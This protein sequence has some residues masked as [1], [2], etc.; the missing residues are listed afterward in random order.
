MNPRLL[1]ATAAA[2]H[3]SGLSASLRTKSAAGYLM[4]IPYAVL[5]VV[6]IVVPVLAAILLS[7]TNFNMLEF[8]TWKGLENYLHLFL[9]DD[10]FLIAL[11]NTLLY[12]MITGPLGYLLS[13]MMAWFVNELS[14][15]ARS[16]LTLL[17]Y[18]PTLAGNIYFIWTYLFSGD[19]YGLINSLL[20]TTG[21]IK[22]PLQWLKDP[23][24]SSAVVIVV[25]IW[26]SMGT[27]FLSLIA[28][29]QSLNHELFEAAA[30]DGVR[31][32]YQELWYVTLPQMVPQLL[33]AAV[34]SISSAFAVGY[35]NAALTGFPSTDYATH[36]I[37]LHILDYGSIRF[38]MGYASA[39]AV[40]LF[41]LMTGAYRITAKLIGKVGT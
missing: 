27:G 10:I 12:A 37:L 41:I 35:Q 8:P 30:I 31:N 4:M 15:G 26:L 20:M 25:M 13:F 5:F 18:A 29:F 19:Q 7:F 23:A 21:F 36:T 24:L 1:P 9:D 39:I 16:G 28:G 32:R 38:E 11:K 6:F 2:K 34:M 3:P 14:R 40:V 33:F 22:D 17:F